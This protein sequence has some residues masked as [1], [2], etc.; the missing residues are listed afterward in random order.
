[1]GT[2]WCNFPHS[3]ILSQLRVAVFTTCVQLF[4]LHWFVPLRACCQRRGHVSDCPHSAQLTDPLRSGRHHRLRKLNVITSAALYTV[5][6]V[7]AVTFLA[8]GHDRAA[9]L[10]L[11]GWCS[12][13]M[14]IYNLIVTLKLLLL[15][16]VFL[17]F[18]RR[19]SRHIA[20]SIAIARALRTRQAREIGKVRPAP[21]PP[22]RRIHAV[23]SHIARGYGLR[24]QLLLTCHVYLA[25]Q[26]VRLIL[27][28][29]RPLRCAADSAACSDGYYVLADLR[30]MTLLALLPE[31]RRVPRRQ[32]AASRLA[33]ALAR[34]P[35]RVAA[36]C[37]FRF[38]CG[39]YY[40]L[41]PHATSRARRAAPPPAVRDRQGAA[42][43][44]QPGPGADGGQCWTRRVRT[45]V[46]QTS[47]AILA[48]D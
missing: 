23:F 30:W 48:G 10:C 42:D 28:V 27:F 32:C 46:C 5:V 47:V 15:G 14:L 41:H 26:L 13:L 7:S 3:P 31:V 29:E 2:V 12:V 39:C 17:A 45:I 9:C 20:A 1:M 22:P 40:H 16:L 38:V 43:N 25:C 19:V 33:K 11:P 24:A 34:L 44:R 21:R 4:F 8:V 37:A 6:A 18:L 36:D 35:A